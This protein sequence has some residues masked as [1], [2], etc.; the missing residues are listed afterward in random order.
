MTEEAMLIEMIWL[1]LRC[2]ERAMG[3]AT[4]FACSSEIYQL[5]DEPQYMLGRIVEIDSNLYGY[6][7]EGWYWI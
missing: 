4:I 7:D 5:L 1:S 2:F 3:K 6:T